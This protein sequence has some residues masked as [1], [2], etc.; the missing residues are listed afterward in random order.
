MP[1]RLIEGAAL[2]GARLAAGLSQSQLAGLL[3]VTTVNVSRW[4]RES[5]TPALH[6]LGELAGVLGVSVE[7]LVVDEV[8]GL[9]TLRARR[10]A[11]GLTQ[12]EAAALAGVSVH[13]YGRLERARP[14]LVVVPEALERV[15]PRVWPGCATQ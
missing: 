12:G 8:R 14:G 11:A 1:D 6:R 4:E 13:R 9:R 3:G 5:S 2:R 10:V 15:L 7:S